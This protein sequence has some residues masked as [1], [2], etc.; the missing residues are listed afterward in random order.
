MNPPCFPH[1]YG[2]DI[3]ELEMSNHNTGA[4]M[5]LELIGID[6]FKNSCPPTL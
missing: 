3:V 1:Q 5:E 6:F 4:Y 2:E